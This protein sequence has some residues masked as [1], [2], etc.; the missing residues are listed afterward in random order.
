M[1]GP[2]CV[3]YLAWSHTL[4]VQTPPPT[5]YQLITEGLDGAP[6][7]QAHNH[8]VDNVTLNYPCPVSRLRVVSH[9]G[10]QHTFWISDGD[11]TPLGP[12]G[13]PLIFFSIDDGRS[14]I[15]RQH[16]PGAHHL[17]FSSIDGGRYQILLQHPLGSPPSTFSSI[18]GGRSRIL[19]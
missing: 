15:L 7:E 13:R 12:G 6:P 5:C 11:Q 9:T 3:A 4:S 2:V 18:D 17:H 19:R 8:N 16:L 1:G 10:L 14:Q